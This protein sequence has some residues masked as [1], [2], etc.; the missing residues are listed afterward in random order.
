MEQHAEKRRRASHENIK[1]AILY[2]GIEADAPADEQDVL[3]EVG[4][5]AGVLT[6][7][8]LSQVAIPMTLDLRKAAASLKKVKPALV[9]NLVESLEGSGRFIHMAPALLDHLRIPYTGAPTEAMFTSSNKLLSKQM[10]AA[11]DIPTLPWVNETGMRAGT[12]SFDPPWI[13]KSCWEHASI[14]VHEHSV[15]RETKLLKAALESRADGTDRSLYL[16]P[17]ID[18]REFNIA[19]LGGDNGPEVL[20]PSEILFTDFPEGKPKIVDYTAKWVEDSFEYENTPRNYEFGEEDAALL[21]TMKDISLRCWHLFGL[22]GWARVDFRVD[23]E[24]RPW[25]M[26]VNAN[27]CINPESGFV[28]TAQEVGLDY[29]GIIERIIQDSVPGFTLSR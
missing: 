17:Y 16:E 20:P 29:N 10:M 9:F 22:R 12:V 25:V 13:L 19:I 14:G 21:D 7:P 11:A 15:I 8:G 27:P 23:P 28:Y 6:R 5:I 24:G 4:G 18:G 3:E 26:E 1:I 2:G